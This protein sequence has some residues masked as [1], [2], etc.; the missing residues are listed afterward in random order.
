MGGGASGCCA[1]PLMHRIPRA[2]QSRTVRLDL[3]QASHR[4]RPVDN[5]R[6]PLYEYVFGFSGELGD[7]GLQPRIG[8]QMLAK[9]KYSWRF[10]AAAPPREVFA[11][12][13]QLIGVQ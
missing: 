11:V 2:F 5:S 13:E 9:P 8:P 7:G 10:V 1:E 4:R 12:M 6:N 3:G